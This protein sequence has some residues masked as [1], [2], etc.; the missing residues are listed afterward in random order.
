MAFTNEE[1]S[2]L[3]KY[4]SNPTGNIFIVRNL[5]GLTGP[6]FARYS[7]APG[8]FREILLNEFIKEG[9]VDAQKAQD[10]IHRVLIAFG[11]ES[12]GELEGSHISLE[13][14]SNVATKVIEDRR[15]GGSPI[16]QSSRYVVYDQLDDQ[17]NFRYYR[18]KNIMASAHGQSFVEGMDEIFRTYISLVEPMNAFFRKLKP[19]EEAEYAIKPNDKTKYRLE[20]LTDDR[21]IKDF[22]RTYKFDIKT[23]A[24]DTIRV[25]LPAATKTNVGIFGNGRFFNHMLTHL[26]S[27]EL[28]EMHEHAQKAHEELNK[29]IPVFVKRAKRN[30]YMVETERNMKELASHLTKEISLQ[31]DLEHVIL[32]EQKGDQDYVDNMVAQMLFKYTNLSLPILRI[33]AS[34]LA[35]YRKQQVIQT[36]VGNRKTRFDRSGR[37]LEYGYPLTFNLRGDFGIYRDLHRMRMLTQ[38][39]QLLTTKLGF[40]IPQSIIDAGHEE[41]INKCISISS[42]LWERIANDVSPEAAQYAV[43]FGF[44]IQWMIGMNL[45]EAQHMLELRTIPQGHPNYRKMCQEMNRQIMEKFPQMKAATQFIDNNDYFWSRGESE[46]RQRQKE[47]QFEEGK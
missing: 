3:S 23:K 15:I 9:V 14:I 36:Y 31:Q 19:I 29:Q 21:E 27:H 38:E 44:N 39:R 20:Q 40:E 8:G 2:Q 25:L 22:E 6:I 4:V 28:P 37:A 12:V 16:E 24:C 32:L 33:I 5:P 43:L 47:R 10:L 18:D 42:S 30:E 7:R 17:G 13:D 26:Y 35:N 34:H 1:I 41:E 45:R 46:A 11:D